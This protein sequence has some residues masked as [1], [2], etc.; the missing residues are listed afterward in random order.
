MLKVQPD[1]AFSVPPVRAHAVGVLPDQER[2]EAGEAPLV[3]VSYV[4]V[5]V[6][7]TLLPSTLIAFGLFM[8][9]F[10][11]WHLPLS[12]AL[13]YLC[14]ILGDSAV[15]ATVFLLICMISAVLRKPASAAR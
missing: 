5:A 12:S 15:A 11:H 1:A 6:P 13:L 10:I 2:R 14:L 3:Q 8:I 9:P 4:L 7:C